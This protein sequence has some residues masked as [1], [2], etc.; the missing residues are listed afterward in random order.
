MNVFKIQIAD[1]SSK[2]NYVDECLAENRITTHIDFARELIE[3]IKPGDIGIVHKGSHA[4]CLIKVLY[5]ITDPTEVVGTSFG[6]DFKVEILQYYKE[7]QDT[8]SLKDQGKNV[9]HNGTYTL[10]QENSQKPVYNFITSWYNLIKSKMQQE[11]IIKVL[12]YKKQIIL[13]GP[14]GTGKTYM[15]E[16]I[17]KQL[18][19]VETVSNPMELL[20]DFYKSFD[21]QDTDIIQQRQKRKDLKERFLNKFPKEHIKDLGLEEYCIGTGGNDSFCWWIE[22][23]LKVLGYYFPGSALS[24]R[25][26]WSKSKDEYVKS[27]WIK[28]IE[29]DTKAMKEVAEALH[30]LINTRD[31]LEGQKYFGNSFILKLLNTYYPEEYA[32]VNAVNYIKNALALFSIDDTDLDFVQLN[33]RLLTL[34]HQKNKEFSKDLKPHE[35]MKFLVE[36]FNLKEGEK[37]DADQIVAKGDYELVQFHPAYSYEDF[38]R[39]IVAEVVEKQ[40]TFNVKNKILAQFAERAID[41]PKAKFIL[42]IDEINR[43]NLPAVLGE[44]IYALEYRGKPV[45]SLYELDEEREISLPNNLFIIGTMN[46]ADRSVGHIDYAI[47]RRFAFK[48]VLPNEAL[49]PSF[50]KDKFQTVS[51]LFSNEFLSSDFRKNDVQIGHS[52]FMAKDKEELDIKIKYEVIPILKEYV[53]DGVLS[54]KALDVISTL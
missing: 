17:A 43:A 12:E 15:A 54:N 4:V 46:T 52:Y 8:F 49:V 29:D 53:K 40:P 22:R 14:P 47:R 16:A 9:G 36:N 50:A 32:P 28:E 44:L 34:H 51:G 13:Q 41:N 35:F 33:Q 6:H 24:Y 48:D 21:S 42:I 5:K 30:K 39:G 20:N 1:G 2:K 7:L 27:G 25:I 23:G 37:L 3:T 26:Y 11:E 38:V 19:E 31:Y 10:W 18:T 45:N